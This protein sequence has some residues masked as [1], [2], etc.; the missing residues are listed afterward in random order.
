MTKK[1]IQKKEE[2]LVIYQTKSGALELRGD[3]T[4]D[5]VWASQAQMAEVFGVNSQ[6]VTKHIKNIYKEAELVESATCSILEQVQTEGGRE[7]TRSV[8]FYNLDVIIAVGYRINSVVG[9]NFRIWATKTLRQHITQGYT[10]NP[11]RVAKNYDSFMAA[12]K[13]VQAVLPAGGVVDTN[14]VLNLVRLFADTWFSL[15]AYDKETL[16]PAKMSK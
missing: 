8:K 4:N 14:E 6:A 7:I 1:I 10:I 5:T 2:E 13:Q 12:V 16:A 9:T 3:F 11:K 15:D